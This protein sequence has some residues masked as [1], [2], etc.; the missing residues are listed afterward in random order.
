MITKRDVIL[1][2]SYFCDKFI[3]FSANKAKKHAYNIVLVLCT[4]YT[5]QCTVCTAQCTLYVH[6]CN[7][8]RTIYIAYYIMAC[9][10]HCKADAN[11]RRSFP[12]K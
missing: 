1:C 9:D 11:L 10:M 5:V 2:G 12:E 8:Q 7:M 6:Y 3:P 4:L